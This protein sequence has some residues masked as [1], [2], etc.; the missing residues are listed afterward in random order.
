MGFLS[1]CRFLRGSLPLLGPLPCKG[2]LLSVLSLLAPSLCLS[3][4]PSSP[5]GSFLSY[6]HR[7]P[8]F[9]F[10]A[11]GSLLRPLSVQSHSLTSRCFYEEEA[12]PLVQLGTLFSRIHSPRFLSD[13]ITSCNTNK[14]CFLFLRFVSWTTSFSFLFFFSFLSLLSPWWHSLPIVLDSS[15]PVAYYRFQ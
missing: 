11:A 14:L 6:S 1:P 15:A 12:T 10:L 9:L 3:F 4:S 2:L 13:R 8:L 5:P 7:F